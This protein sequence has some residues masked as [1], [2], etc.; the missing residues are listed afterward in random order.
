MVAPRG[1][2]RCLDNVADEKHIASVIVGDT[3]GRNYEPGPGRSWYAG[4]QI[5][6]RF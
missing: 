2:A 3:N 6:Y 1:W 4:V 5:T